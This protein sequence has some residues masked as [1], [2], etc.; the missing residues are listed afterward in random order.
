MQWIVLDRGSEVAIG[1]I[2]CCIWRCRCEAL[3]SWGL[4]QQLWKVGFDFAFDRPSCLGA[5]VLVS[6]PE[7]AFCSHEVCWEELRG[8]KWNDEVVDEWC[9]DR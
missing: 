7:S 9:T 3:C 2:P 5:F 4:A 6:E 1:L 8:L